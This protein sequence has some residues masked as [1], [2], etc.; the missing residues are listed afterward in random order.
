MSFNSKRDMFIRKNMKNI[1]KF[2]DNY[3]IDKK[4]LNKQQC[5]KISQDYIYNCDKAEIVTK[6][7][8][9]FDDN[10][11]DNTIKEIDNYKT[12]S[13]TTNALEKV[14]YFKHVYKISISDKDNDDKVSE[15]I[16]KCISKRIQ[17]KYS[18]VPEDKHDKG[19][20]VEILRHIFYKKRY[21]D[22]KDVVRRIREKHMEIKDEL[23]KQDMEFKNLESQLSSD[24]EFI[25]IV[26]KSIKKRTRIKRH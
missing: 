22:V 8:E 24:E 7:K 11:Y 25:P 20:N 13:D 26:S 9:F 1:T 2:E 4:I 5:Y 16:N 12:L 21:D 19:H 14:I 17:Y 15:Y 6:I 23:Y 18:C 10:W 3:N